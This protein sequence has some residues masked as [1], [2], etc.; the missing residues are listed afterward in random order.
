[1]IRRLA[2]S[3][4]SPS[5]L[6]HAPWEFQLLTPAERKQVLKMRQRILRGRIGPCERV[7]RSLGRW[8]DASWSKFK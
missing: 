4:S 6:H 7:L 8:M 2:Q 1:M 5:L 3:S